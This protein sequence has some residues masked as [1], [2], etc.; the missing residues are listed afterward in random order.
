MK[1][2]VQFHDELGIHK[3]MRVLQTGKK[4]LTKSLDELASARTETVE[5]QH[6]R[7]CS[8]GDCNFNPVR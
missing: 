6:H 1:K 7:N 5:K 4:L 2:I 3:K 8:K